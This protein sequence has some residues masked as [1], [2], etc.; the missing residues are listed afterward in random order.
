VWGSRREETFMTLRTRPGSLAL[1]F[2]FPPR[3]RALPLAGLLAFAGC[4][5]SS[6]GNPTPAE[7]SGAGGRGTGGRAGSGGMNGPVDPGAGGSGGASSGGAAGTSTGGASGGDVDAAAPSDMALPEAG[8]PPQPPPLPQEEQPLPACKKT[9]NVNAPGEL[10]GAISGAQPGDCIVLADG[11][12]TFPAITKTATEGAP[13][14]IRAANRGK[15]VIA[16]G[17]LD[18][19]NSSY[20]VVEGITF[21]SNGSINFNDSQYCRITRIRFNPTNQAGNDWVN[22]KG[23]S[24]HNRI[25]HS[26]FGPKT[27]LG[28]TIMFGGAGSQV[29]QHNRVDHNYFHDI[30]GGGGNGWE[31]LRIG[32]SGWGP[33]KGFN[34]VEFNLFRAATGDPET[35][36]VKSSDNIIR[37]NTYRATN[38]EITLRHGNR[39]MVYGN[40]M[41]ADGLAAARGIRVLGADH[42][43]FN[44][45]L[46]GIVGSNGI[47][48][49]SGSADGTEEN[50]T[51]FYRVYR[52]HIVNN[53]LVGSKGI[54]V[55]STGLAP[56][57]CVVANNIVQNS[58]GGAI[59]DV[60]DKTKI[61]GNIVNPVEGGTVGVTMGAKMVNPMLVKM[62]GVFRLG[63]GSPAIDAAVGSY[64][65]VMDDMD[66]QP[67][68]AADV[69]ADELVAG[70][71]IT[72]RPLGEADVGPNS[73]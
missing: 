72:R 41:L 29:V 71:N 33:S 8:T 54:I 2:A 32:L 18:I 16:S 23:K 14:V 26:E 36:S 62:D 52:T 73:P 22:I 58:L 70:G 13:I 44:N 56:V 65:Y 15:A 53:T 9:T 6:P 30:K 31:T 48:L 40:F 27:V 49:R 25:D 67:R 42:R 45:Y 47:F 63:M 1:A 59:T 19:T 57:E 68:N 51:E 38:G 10:A 55:G 4:A 34:L 21:T 50:G 11:T 5:S 37:Y 60:G 24:H 20:V 39:T 28:N 43:I 7:P 69:G 17:N 3:L 64:G 12:Y 66:G 61:E 35:I 46:E